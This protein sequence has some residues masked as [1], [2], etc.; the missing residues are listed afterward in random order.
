MMRTIGA[1]VTGALVAVA[2]AHATTRFDGDW[3]V[4]LTCPPTSD[5]E[6][7]K[8][9]AFVFPVRIEQGQLDGTRGKPGEPGWEHLYGAVGDDGQATLTLD[10]IVNLSEYAIGKSPSGKP[11]T[12]SVSARFTDRAGT[13]RRTSGRPCDFGFE[14]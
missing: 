8:G 7:A 6:G 2:A 4:T 9:Y 14:R 5:H 13:G 3:K 1:A 12:Y 10:G 11:F